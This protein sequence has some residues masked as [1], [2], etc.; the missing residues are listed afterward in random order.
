MQVYTI[1]L[2]GGGHIGFTQFLNKNKLAMFS[3]YLQHM[4]IYSIHVSTLIG[5]NVMHVDIINLVV[6][7]ILDLYTFHR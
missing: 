5:K 2:R 1:N 6:A 4:I 3:L 7:A